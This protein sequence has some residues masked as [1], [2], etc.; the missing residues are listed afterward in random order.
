MVKQVTMTEEETKSAPA[1]WFGP[2]AA[3]VAVT[4]IAIFFD[5]PVLRQISGFVFLTF[6]PGFLFLSILKLNRLGLT[7]KIVLSV[8]LSVAFSMLFGIALNG[9]LLAIGYT[10]PLSTTSLLISFSVATGVMAIIAYMRNRDITFSFPSLKLTTQEKA[11]LVVPSIFPLLS[12]FGMRIMNQSDNNLFLMVMLIAIAAYIIYISFF[13][14]QESERIYPLIIFSISISLLLMYALRS[15]HI[16]GSDV[17]REYHIFLT[18]MENFKWVKLGFGDLDACLSISVLPAVYQTFLNI[19]PE[20]LFKILYSL[21]FSVSPLV[22]YLLARKYI[23]N[24]Y[25]FLATFLFMSQIVFLWTPSYTRTVTGILFFALAIM[26]MFNANISRFNR[27][28]LFI[29]FATITIVS[30]YGVAYAT[31]FILVLTW[32]GMQIFPKIVSRKKETV[33]LPT[34][35]PGREAGLLSSSLQER[36]PPTGNDT[37]YVSA[38][39][40]P[41]YRNGITITLITL[42]LVILFFWYSEVIGST[43]SHGVRFVRDAFVNWEWFLDEGAGSPAVQAAMGKTLPSAVL[44]QRIEFVFSW[45]TVAL[46]SVGLLTVIRKFETMVFTPFVGYEKPNFL[47]KKFEAEYLMLSIGCYLLMVAAVVLP[48]VSESYGTAKT[49]LQLI[50]PLTV[51]FAIGGIEVAK[52]FKLRPQWILVVILIPFFLSTTGVTYQVLGSP[53]AITLNSQGEPYTDMY[54]SDAESN[55]AG[56]L[57]KYSKEEAVT[58]VYGLTRVILLSQGGITVEQTRGDLITLCEEGKQ[59]GG[60]VYLRWRDISD[61]KFEEE[62]PYVFY[63]KNKIYANGKSEVYR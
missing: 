50:V 51:F 32:L 10:T 56:W 17:H 18:T 37:T 35:N 46:M 58:H 7:E 1:K 5:I 45:L 33:T 36:A 27:Q 11:L 63:R 16:I 6:V 13:K 4:N 52:Y 47:L 19:G 53:R 54:I 62:Y 60:Y 15:N 20:Y 14:R 22:V 21:I 57:K 40:Q 3:V 8:G 31:F 12:I 38:P 9:S 26:V 44:P 39:P 43:F 61:Y 41:W 23:G 55:S 49:Y 28:V 2:I 24:F 34:K 30:H 25:A 48:S 42:F 29:I 59:F